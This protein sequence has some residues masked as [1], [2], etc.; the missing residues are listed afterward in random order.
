MERRDEALSCFGKG[1]NCCQSVLSAYAR[2]FG[3][4]D[5]TALR[6]AGVFGGGIA[7]SGETCGAVTGGLMVI[8]LKHGTT[9]PRDLKGKEGSRE[10]AKR[11][12]EGFAALCGSTKCRD[13]LGCD[14]GT[15]EGMERALTLGLFKTLCP[16][17]VGRAV[18][19][20]EETA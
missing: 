10:R 20:L 15:K 9:D 7:G 13:L 16:E 17:F 12:L 6:L 2:D 3:L 4:S 18:D 1:F 8:G 14:M 19:L 5:E 11:F